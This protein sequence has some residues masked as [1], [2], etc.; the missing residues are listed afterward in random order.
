MHKFPAKLCDNRR[1]F[2]VPD[3]SRDFKADW[4]GTIDWNHKC[5][6]LM[7][8]LLPHQHRYLENRYLTVHRT[9]YYIVE[10]VSKDSL[11]RG[12]LSNKDTSSFPNNLTPERRTFQQY[13]HFIVPF[14]VP[15]REFH[16]DMM[17]GRQC[18][19]SFLRIL[20]ERQHRV[21]QCDELCLG[22]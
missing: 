17:C 4:N 12:H 15:I 10:P 21:P 14:G 2:H 19:Y 20:K 1:G 22:Q 16:C 6:V 9:E 8:Q 18:T 3:G 13:G 7:L 11:K 5:S